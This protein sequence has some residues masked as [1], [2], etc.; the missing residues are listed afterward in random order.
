M[1]NIELK[2]FSVPIL[3]SATIDKEFIINGIAISETTTSNGHKFIAEELRPAG[4]KLKGIPLLKDHENSVDKIVGR[5]IS[6]GFDEIES[7][8]KFKAKVNDPQMK[9]LIERGDLNSVS[10]GATVRELEETKEGDLI[11][12]GINIKELSLVAVPADSNATFGLALREAY[13]AQNIPKH[14]NI[15][16]REDKKMTEQDEKTPEVEKKEENV[17]AKLLKK[18][19]VEANKKLAEFAAKERKVLEEEYKSLCSS[20]KVISLDVSELDNK[21]LNI[22]SNQVKA[23]ADADEEV[24]VEVEDEEEDEGEESEEEEVEASDKSYIVESG[25][26]DLGGGRLTLVR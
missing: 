10:I 19:L 1:E 24:K 23:M 9:A 8:I 6:S 5:V 4:S 7:N 16:A 15:I 20:K 2:H 21:M 26:G 22:L 25:F 11:A 17:E 18:E 3:E 13:N 12:R 14:I